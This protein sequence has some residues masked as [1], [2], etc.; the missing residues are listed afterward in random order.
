MVLKDYLF[1]SWSF[2]QNLSFVL[3]W[4]FSVAALLSLA[5]FGSTDYELNE[6][7][8]TWEIGKSLTFKISRLNAVLS[9]VFGFCLL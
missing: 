9:C 6:V 5:L 4:G 1:I 7:I 8:Q 3:I 2:L